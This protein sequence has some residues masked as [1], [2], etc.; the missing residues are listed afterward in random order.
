[1]YS[2]IEQYKVAAVYLTVPLY[3][4]PC[5]LYAKKQI[6]NPTKKNKYTTR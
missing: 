2:I 5:V 6:A 3:C 4:R 1:M